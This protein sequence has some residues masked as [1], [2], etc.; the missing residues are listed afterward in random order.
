MKLMVVFEGLQTILL[1]LD[2]SPVG[3]GTQIVLGL[4]TNKQ[5]QWAVL[6]KMLHIYA[7]LAQAASLL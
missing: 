7:T 3:Y 6:N 2:V 1:T 5:T 4:P